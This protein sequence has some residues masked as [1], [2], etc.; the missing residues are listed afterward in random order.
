MKTCDMSRRIILTL[1][2]LLCCATAPATADDASSAAARL[3]KCDG[4]A[5]E[6]PIPT[7]E[8][9]QGSYAVVGLKCEPDDGFVVVLHQTA[10]GWSAPI[11]TDASHLQQNPFAVSGVPQDVASS[12]WATWKARGTGQFTDPAD[13]ADSAAAIAAARAAGSA[14]PNAK[15]VVGPW[16]IGPWAEALWSDGIHGNG[17]IV[18]HKENGKWIVVVWGQR[19][20]GGPFHLS[21]FGMPYNIAWRLMESEHRL[22]P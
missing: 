14:H 12:L 11:K 4:Q 9:V 2:I 13:A 10:S 22:E 16:I 8:L 1:L 17:D 19:L 18:L 5:N 21:A 20:L 7:A 15:A 6:T 3:A